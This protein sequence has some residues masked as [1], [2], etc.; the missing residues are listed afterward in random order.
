MYASAGTEQSV[1]DAPG[2]APAARPVKADN[3]TL[4]SEPKPYDSPPP[5][6]QY[7]SQSAQHTTQPALMSQRRSSQRRA[8][9]RSESVGSEVEVERSQVVDLK[10]PKPKETARHL[11][12]QS[13]ISHRTMPL[14][15]AKAAYKECCKL[16]RGEQSVRLRLGRSSL[17][18]TGPPHFGTANHAVNDADSFE[19]FVAELEPG[20]ALLGL[21]IKTG[22]D[23]EGGGRF[24]A[25]V[26]KQHSWQSQT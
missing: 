21:E 1:V 10:L 26:T 7:L 6:A 25:I 20:L 3:Q 4:I 9:S 13:L 19:T 12:L 2:S 24:V 16:C 22:I 14:P 18:L 23:Q 8:R 11:F 17:E 15:N 5:P